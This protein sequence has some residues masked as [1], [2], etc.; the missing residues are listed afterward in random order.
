MPGADG[1]IEAVRLVDGAFEISCIGDALAGGDLRLRAGGPARGAAAGRLDVRRGAGSPA[2]PGDPR[3]RPSRGS[4]CRAATSATSRSRRRPPP[5]ASGCCSAASG[6]GPEDLDHVYLA[7]G[8]ANALDIESAIEH[9]AAGARPRRSG[10]SGPATRPSAAP[11]RCYCPGDGARR[12]RPSSG[13]SSTWSSNP[14][15]TSSTCSPTAACSSRSPPEDA[16]EPHVPPT[17]TRTSRADVRPGDAAAAA[18]TATRRRPPDRAPCAASSAPR[19]ASPPIVELVPWAG[20]LADARGQK[21]LKM[22]ADL[23]GNPRITAPLGHRQRR[24]PRPPRARTRPARRLRELG[25]DVIVHVACRDRNRN[26]HAEPRLGPPVPR[27]DHGPGDHRRLP[28][29]GLRGP[30]AA[31]VRHRLGGAARAP[32]RARRGRSRQGRRRRR[33]RPESHYDFFLGCAIDPFKRLE[34]DLVPQFLKLALKVRAGA[35][36][37]ITQVGYDAHRQDELLR[38]MRRE[39]IER[40]RRRQRLHPERHR[41]PGR[42][43][44]ARSRA[45]WSRTSCS[46]SWSEK[47]ATGPDKGRAFFLEFAA[48]QLVVSRGLGFRGIYI[49]G[50]RDAAEVGRVLEMA[51]AHDAADW[52]SLV[53]DVSFG[54]CR[55][56]SSRSRRTATACPPTS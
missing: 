10:S 44:P 19:P 4:R 29:R 2:G 53:Q 31:R 9:R 3:G 56:R 34:R 35:D 43:T 21:P 25:H 23:A 5:S 11:A 18:T 41:S 49:S 54:P 26:A 55:A 30:A 39:G 27:P 8:F 14:S 28:G 40:A 7:G 37:A 16:D 52:R 32:A 47:A 20:E 17:P 12:W 50:H 1:A 36:Y 24:R 42:S 38:W 48:K 22:A 6:S 46:R 15:Q 13:G 45:A 51:D 33:G